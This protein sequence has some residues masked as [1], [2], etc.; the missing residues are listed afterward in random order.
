MDH[1]SL[2]IRSSEEIIENMLHWSL[3]VSALGV[4]VAALGGYAGWILFPN[5]VH[6][7]VE[8]VSKNPQQKIFEE[9]KK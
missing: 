3:I 4:C 6:K 7:K 9:F 5:M 1:L 2:G 8:Q